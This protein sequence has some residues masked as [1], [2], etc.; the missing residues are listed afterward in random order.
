VAKVTLPISNGFYVSASLPISNQ[1]CVNFR[2]NI[3]QAD[4]VTQDN[5]FGTPGIRQLLTLGP[6][7]IGRGSNVMADIAYTVIGP[8]LYRI[9]RQVIDEMCLRLMT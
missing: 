8:N 3:P 2:P 5:L 1:R 7:I 6:N 4:T 9:N